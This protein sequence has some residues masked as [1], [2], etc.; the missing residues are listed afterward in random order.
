VIQHPL[1]NPADYLAEGPHD[2][3][4]LV[5]LHE[6]KGPGVFYDLAHRFP[7]RKFLA[8]RGG[9]G[10]QVEKDLPNVE[11]VDNTPNIR[12]EVYARTRILLMPSEYESFGRVAIEAAASGIPTIACPTPGLLEAI[13]PLGRYAARDDLDAWSEHILDLGK[14]TVYRK[15]SKEAVERAGHW[16]RKA[17]EEFERTLAALEQFKN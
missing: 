6:N 17:E 9:Y 16:H 1:M 2:H 13:G 8:V 3:I 14:P 11:F 12:E 4:T 15:A 5:N 10:A 7:R